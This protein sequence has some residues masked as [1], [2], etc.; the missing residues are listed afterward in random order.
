MILWLSKPLEIVN[1]PA[2]S[3]KQTPV[4][5]FIAC[6][7]VKL[8]ESVSTSKL[9]VILAT[10]ESNF[11]KRLSVSFPCKIHLFVYIELFH[12]ERFYKLY[13]LDRGK[14]IHLSV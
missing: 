10:E 9:I 7:T 4:F 1:S 6:S 3:L 11:G 8:P 2:I 5:G 14:S 12:K 13:N